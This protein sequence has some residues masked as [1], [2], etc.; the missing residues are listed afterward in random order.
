MNP[1]ILI[2]SGLLPEPALTGHEQHKKAGQ[3]SSDLIADMPFRVVK[4]KAT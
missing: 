2:L 3:A 1:K 4:S